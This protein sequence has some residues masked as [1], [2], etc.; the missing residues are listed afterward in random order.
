VYTRMAFRFVATGDSVRGVIVCP[1]MVIGMQH[2]PGDSLRRAAIP[3]L[4]HPGCWRDTA[5]AVHAEWTYAALPPS[6]RFTVVPVPDAPRMRVESDA[7]RDTVWV[8][9]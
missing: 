1:A 3:S 6:E 5:D 8:I 9:W 2:P 7:S 4:D